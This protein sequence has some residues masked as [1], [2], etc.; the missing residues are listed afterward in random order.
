MTAPGLWQINAVVPAVS[1]IGTVPVYV[2][3]G[4]MPSNAVTIQAE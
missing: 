1:A 3:A 2:T 4:G